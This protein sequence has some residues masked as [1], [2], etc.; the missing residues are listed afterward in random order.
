M[1]AFEL[2]LTDA[3]SIILNFDFKPEPFLDRKDDVIDC[4]EKWNFKKPHPIVRKLNLLIPVRCFTKAL[5]LLKKSSVELWSNQFI[6]Y[7]YEQA[8][9]NSYIVE[10][11]YQ[12]FV[13]V[14]PRHDFNIFP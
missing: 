7:S 2:F 12:K 13:K 6:R 14:H 4:T 3:D 9:I 5:L 8:R 11:N 10:N 1:A